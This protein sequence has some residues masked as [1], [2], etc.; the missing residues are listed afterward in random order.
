MLQFEIGKLF[1]RQYN[2][3]T[4]Q[5]LSAEEF[6]KQEYFDIF[7]N[8]PQYLQWVINSPL[9]K[10]TRTERIEKL[11]NAQRQNRLKILD[12]KIETME[13]DGSFAIGFPAS[14]SSKFATTS[15]CV[16][17]FDVHYS[18]DDIYASWIGSGLGIGLSGGY[19]ILPDDPKLL[20]IIYEGWKVY[21]E[22]VNNEDIPI[23]DK[24][25]NSWNGQ[26]LNYILK[27]KVPDF[28]KMFESG[29]FKED[30]KILRV[31]TLD[32]NR[33]YFTIL[34]HHSVEPINCYVYLLGQMNKTVGIIPFDFEI[35]KQLLQKFADNYGPFY[36]E[37]IVENI[38]GLSLSKA[39]EYGIIDIRSLRPK[40]IMTYTIEKN[41][42]LKKPVI[43]YKNNE[44]E[45]DFQIRKQNLLN[46]DKINLITYYCYKTWLAMV[47]NKENLQDYTEKVAKI[48]FEYSNKSE[49]KKQVL[50]LLSSKTRREFIDTLSSIVAKIDAKFLGDVKELM[51]EVHKTS[52]DNFRYFLS[53]INFSY[54]FV[55]RD[56]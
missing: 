30:K 6:F 33:L 53:M 39:C 12:E 7:F 13:P 42:R 19:C 56:N 40:K 46:K 1:L 15:G 10:Q 45:E 36:E 23:K 54:A 32:W 18:K 25:I 37:D 28:E 50:E 52:P 27:H 26:Y 3:E 14:E 21:R 17:E 44:E 47:Q 41:L 5:D 43:K 11:N 48:L 51:V 8:H 20:M 2:S 22:Y 34:R 16:S 29:M 4:G 35:G 24:Q 9:I 49:K 55:E 31:D 38:F